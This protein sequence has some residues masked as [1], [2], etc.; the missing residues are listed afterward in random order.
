M[1]GKIKIL[2]KQSAVYGLGSI[3]ARAITFLL[4]PYY[5]HLMNPAEY[6]VLQLF[7]IFVAILQ[8]IYFHGMDIAYLR[9]S[10]GSTPG[11][12]KHDL[13]MVLV[14]SLAVAIF[15]SLP[16]YLF[17]P[18]ISTIVVKSVGNEGGV[19][20]RIAAFLITSDVLGFHL[21]TFLRIRGRSILYVT[22]KLGNVTL[23]VLLNILLLG[24]YEMGVTGV[25][26]AYLA[27]S[28]LTLIIL[29]FLLWREF[30]ITW[31]WKEIRQWMAFGLPNVPSMLFF[32]A[33]E[34]SDRKFQES[35]MDIE[36]AGIY[37]AGYKIGMLMSIVAQAFRF[38]WQ[39]FIMQTSE[40]EDAR[41]T[42]A[43]VMTYY[44]AFAGLL[45]LSATFFL[46][47]FLTGDLPLVGVLID[48]KYWACMGIFPIIMLAHIFNGLYANLMVGVYLENK[49]R[50][51]PL[52]IGFAA[53]INIVGNWFLI[54]IYGYLASAWLTVAS[55]ALMAVWMYLY[56]NP[57]YP[58]RY[59]WKRLAG[60]SVLI[61]LSW[62]GSVLIPLFT[63]SGGK[64]L[65]LVI[66]FLIGW[67]FILY[68]EE[69]KKILEILHLKR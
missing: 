2:A 69:R 35:L 56:I 13:G 51:I 5:S 27:T 6:G 54:P 34:F 60:I 4:L 19:L 44:L 20:I 64:L 49:T 38:A 22:L 65:L 10:A 9:Y 45:W 61:G 42:Y 26:L 25:F 39:P 43:R 17:A 62:G 11:K 53:L 37:S 23:F 46:T 66:V 7:L 29:I 68:T 55:Y 47:G 21:F 16:L 31:N 40:D 33:V 48:R 59:E 8:P 63:T 15:L 58:I 52:I 18:S 14:H 24:R 36:S 67:K 3:G 50:I 32:V 57:R 30:S 1:F 28:V 41:E 12:Q